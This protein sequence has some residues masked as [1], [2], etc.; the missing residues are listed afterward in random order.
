MRPPIACVKK[1]GRKCCLDSI[2]DLEEN[3][4]EVVA[5]HTA[6]DPMNEDVVFTWMSPTQIAE[7]L[8]E[9]GMPVCRETVDTLLDKLDFR[10]R[11]A[12]KTLAMGVYPTASAHR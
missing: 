2:P 9:R 8:A 12:Q 3:F 10:R 11:Q 5:D 6:G 7:Q 1:G 4:R